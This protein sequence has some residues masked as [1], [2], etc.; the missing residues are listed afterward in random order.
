MSEG[1][2]RR[3]RRVVLA[4]GAATAVAAAGVAAGADRG[5]SGPRPPMAAEPETAV[6]ERRDLVS[7]ERF[8]GTLGHGP[9]TPIVAPRGGRL[10][11]HPP[12]GTPVGRGEVLYEVDGAGVELFLG[13]RP[14]WRTLA[15]GADPGPDVR[16][17]EEN[18]VAL[19]A[20]TPAQ[21]GVDD[22]FTAATASALRRWQTARGR[23]A[24]GTL[25]PTDV[26]VH[27]AGLRVQG[28]S[29]PLGAAVS[30]GVPIVTATSMVEQVSVDVDGHDVALL[31]VGAGAEV[32]LPGGDVR[33]GRVASVAPAPPNT[34]GGGDR[35]AAFV[36][37]VV[38]DAPEAAAREGTPVEVRVSRRRAEGVLAVPVAA[39][40]ARPGG[41][42]SVER[43][44]AGRAPEPV[45]V[46]VGVV[47]DGLA[48]VRGPLRPGQRVVVAPV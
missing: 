17:L 19:G 5:G 24:T 34:E 13:T 27:P 28:V 41:G 39:L 1:R 9:S 47:A 21:L 3:A 2:L 31:P 42:Y 43:V 15:V 33:P 11:A 6:V 29:V 38:V 36:V 35:T 16:Q 22:R 44:R 48:E 12:V 46:E 18:L 32:V 8:G 37:A 20:A 23:P 4:V 14:F 40:L 10:T 26:A 7:T 30:P 45:A 25:E